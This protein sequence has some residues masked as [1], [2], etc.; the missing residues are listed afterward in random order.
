MALSSGSL[1]PAKTGFKPSPFHP[2]LKP[3]QRSGGGIHFWPASRIVRDGAGLGPI[4]ARSGDLEVRL[5]TTARDIR[6]A[7]RLRFKVFYQE[8]SAV[9]D[10]ISL[11]SRRDM[12][13]YDDLCDHLL[14]ID[15]A[16]KAKPFRPQKPR[17]VG[18]YRLLR[19]SI[20]NAHKGFYTASEFNIQPII[21]ANPDLKFLELGRSC[22]LKPYRTKR[23][24]ELLW[25]GIWSYVTHHQIDVMFGCASLEGTD[26]RQLAVP[27]SFLHHYAQSPDLWRAKAVPER[28]VSMN[29]M[30]K[31]DFDAKAALKALP[32][33]IK[34]YLRVGATFGEGAVIDHQFNTID[35]LVMLP[36]SAIAARYVNH[37]SQG[38]VE[39]AVPVL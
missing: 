20:A 9:P 27:L 29:L 15:H 7:Q 1:L 19:Q 35:V 21:A 17:V 37:F 11:F 2:F 32:P 39:R 31:D 6:K 3:L 24:V 30:D 10:A 33:L 18:T 14:V 23:I 25:Q 36:V 26:P 4:L 5:A 38:A 8:M 22:V 28:F 16:A 12:D 34:G 13:D